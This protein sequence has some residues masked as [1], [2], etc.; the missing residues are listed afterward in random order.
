MSMQF[1]SRDKYYFIGNSYEE[2][3]RAAINTIKEELEIYELCRVAS[4]TEDVHCRLHEY[5]F[6]TS[7]E[8]V[9][10]RFNYIPHKNTDT[11]KIKYIY[12][13]ST[14]TQEI[15]DE[16][17][18]PIDGYVTYRGAILCYCPDYP[19]Y[20]RYSFSIIETVTD[21]T[22]KEIDQKIIEFVK[23]S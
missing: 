22:G 9:K 17:I 6:D 23:E 14:I 5:I 18:K 3:F 4:K 1:K 16:W 8:L 19:N 11:D 15:I 20:V 7:D 21:F 13:E 2:C 10:D 12:K